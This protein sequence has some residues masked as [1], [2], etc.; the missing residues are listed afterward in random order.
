M[1]N[2]LDTEDKSSVFLSLSTDGLSVLIWVQTIVRRQKSPL[3]MKELT[4]TMS[5]S[6]KFTGYYFI[7]TTPVEE[8]DDTSMFVGG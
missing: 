8:N 4:L 6:G 3:T 7:F 1:P 2:G 5:V